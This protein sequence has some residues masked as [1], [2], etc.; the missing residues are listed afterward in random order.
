MAS[1]VDWASQP[2]PVRPGNKLDL[3]RCKTGALPP[4]VCL[5]SRHVGCDIHW[6]GGRSFPHLAKDC[7]ACKDKRPA[8]WKGWIAVWHPK[9]REIGILEFTHRCTE[10]LDAYFLAHGS[11]RGG[12]VTVSR[13]GTKA[14]GKLTLQIVTGTYAVNELPACPDIKHALELMWVA[15]RVEDDILITPT[16]PVVEPPM[17]NDELAKR[18]PDR[19][20]AIESSRLQSGLEAAEALRKRPNGKHTHAEVITDVL[21]NDPN[22]VDRLTL[23][24]AGQLIAQ[25]ARENVTFLN[26][27]GN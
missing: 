17:N 11:C 12:I 9:T 5:S 19:A 10:S 4:L 27:G 1:T 22:T 3:I 13:S 23:R 26:K 20:A 14:N 18:R 24:E 21:I 6:W 16:R 7:P 2:E 25:A 8:V 15:K